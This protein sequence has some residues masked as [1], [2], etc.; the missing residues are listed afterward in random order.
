MRLRLAT[1]LAVSAEAA[2]ALVAT[3][4]L[5]EHIAA[6]LV[7]FSPIDPPAFPQVWEERRYRVRV[8]LGGL[9]PLGYQWIDITRAEAPEGGFRMRD[10]G[11]GDLARKWDHRITISPDGDTS[12]SYVD[13][14]DIEA[15]LLTPMVWSF[16][17]L[18]HAHRQRRWRRLT[19]NNGATAREMLARV[20]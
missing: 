6:P 13:E 19:A 14:V 3:P 9:V 11:R 5:L 18:F 16:A 2:A 7:N 15:G 20:R 8:L 17:L 4:A 12:C 1:K 10:N